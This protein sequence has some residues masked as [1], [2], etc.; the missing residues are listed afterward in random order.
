MELH[1][2]QVGTVLE[3]GVQNESCPEDSIMVNLPEWDE[4]CFHPDELELVTE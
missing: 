1:V 2:G 4:C 3:V